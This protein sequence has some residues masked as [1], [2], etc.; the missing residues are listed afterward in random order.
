MEG[1]MTTLNPVERH[2]TATLRGLPMTREAFE[3]L[4]AEVERLADGLPAVLAPLVVDG[5]GE[6]LFADSVPAA[7]ELH[8]GAQR[9]ATLR[10]AL[11]Q[12]HVVTPNGSAVVG[13]HVLVR[14]EDG[15]LDSYSLVAP[16]EADV[17]AGKISPDSPLGRALLGR[18]VGDTAEVAA[19]GGTRWVTVERVE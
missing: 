19:P 6:D 18:G 1:A 3:R 17:R 7:W 13:S 9:L 12:A 8:V 4:E 15:S 11:A 5:N 10:R 2:A 14:D 16:G